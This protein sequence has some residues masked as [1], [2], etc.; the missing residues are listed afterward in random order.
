MYRHGYEGR[1]F[2]SMST[3]PVTVEAVVWTYWM[4]TRRLRP[5]A[6]RGGRRSGSI[7][8]LAHAVAVAGNVLK[9][10]VA[11]E[12]TPT[13]LNSAELMIAGVRLGAWAAQLP[14]RGDSMS[15]TTVPDARLVLVPD[16]AM[17]ELEAEP[18]APALGVPA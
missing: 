7:L 16:P 2:L 8:A 10:R 17:T 3:V 14:A 1:H 6:L 13:A 12:N 5:A 11:Y 9:T 15:D 18:L 4:L